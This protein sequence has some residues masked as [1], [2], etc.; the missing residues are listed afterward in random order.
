M[1][2]SNE[3]TP[4][5]MRPQYLPGLLKSGK[6]HGIDKL[7]CPPVGDGHRPRDPRGSGW[8][9]H[10]LLKV[11]PGREDPH[12]VGNPPGICPLYRVTGPVL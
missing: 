3:D 1:T 9:K 10:H 2:S 8:L 7:V 12:G 4:R 5:M 11:H 6:I